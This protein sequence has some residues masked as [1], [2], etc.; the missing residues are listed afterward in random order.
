MSAPPVNLQWPPERFY[1]AVLDGSAVPRVNGRMNQ[2]LGY[3]FENVLP[4]IPIEGV[5]AVYQ[6]LP[7]GAGKF[8]AC[9]L[10]Q[11][12]IAQE[13]SP[14]A[15]TLSPNELPG[16]IGKQC[17]SQPT[18]A[19]NLLT[20]AFTPEPIKRLSRRWMFQLAAMLAFGAATI[21]FGLERRARNVHHQFDAIVLKQN[22]IYDNILGPAPT[23][24]QPPALRLLA[25]LRQLE[26]TRTAEVSPDSKHENCTLILAGLMEAWPTELHLQTES[27]SI[28][29]TAVTLRGQVPTMA[30]A[31]GL[32]NALAQLSGWQVAQPQSEAHRDL[33]DVTVRLDRLEKK[34]SP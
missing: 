12:V 23:G 28:A 16:F 20:G 32:A 4:G 30:D 26:L 31:Q 34:G 8:I 6:P 18:P 3:L 15:L 22:A 5:Q 19:L 21:V 17:P 7:G 14:A 2:Q 27:I 11:S 9:G 1:W 13:V 24:S 10:P 25:E 33:V 29:P